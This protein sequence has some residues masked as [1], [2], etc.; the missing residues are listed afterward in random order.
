MLI[1]IGC[2]G[3][4]DILYKPEDLPVPPQIAVPTYLQFASQPNEPVYDLGVS[5]FMT[6]MPGMSYAN[7]AHWGMSSSYGATQDF[8][9]PTP[10]SCSQTMP[11][12]SAPAPQ[13][14]MHSQPAYVA[15]STPPQMVLPPTQLVHELPIRNHSHVSQVSH[16]PHASFASLPHSDFTNQLSG[17]PFRPSRMQL[18]YEHMHASH[19]LPFKTSI[20]KK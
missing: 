5:D 2:S 1:L 9:D 10:Q 16:A 19:H 20:F 12:P 8:F 14:H 18:E 3:H 11:T 6:M 7:S 15:A 4:Y 17:G 13:P